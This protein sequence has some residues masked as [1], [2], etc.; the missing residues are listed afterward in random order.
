MTSLSQAVSLLQ[1]AG[2]QTEQLLQTEKAQIPLADWPLETIQSLAKG[3]AD[4][5]ERLAKEDAMFADDK[6]F[7]T[8]DDEEL[9][10]MLAD[11]TE[12]SRKLAIVL[13]GG[14][15]QFDQYAGH[16]QA[17]QSVQQIFQNLSCFFSPELGKLL[18]VAKLQKFLD[19][20]VQHATLGVARHQH[21]YGHHYGRHAEPVLLDDSIVSAADLQLKG[22]AGLDKMKSLAGMTKKLSEQFER[23]AEAREKDSK[24]AKQK[25]KAA[26]KLKSATAQLSPLLK[27]HALRIGVGKGQHLNISQGCANVDTIYQLFDYKDVEDVHREIEA[28]R[29]VIMQDMTIRRMQANSMVKE[30]LMTE[31][32]MAEAK[33]RTRS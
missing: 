9:K 32:M 3:V 19:D 25:T 13:A 12:S 5:N 23:M 11:M 2:E 21:H 7:S 8:I 30:T 14:L 31:A 6:D 28:A 22:T 17:Q 26:E 4:A 29:N 20:S 27:K 33:K 1:Q 16:R 15:N 24:Q 10:S 18:D